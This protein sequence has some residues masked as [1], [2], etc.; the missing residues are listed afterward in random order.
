LFYS[1]VAPNHNFQVVHPDL[2]V[3]VL[4]A[5]QFDSVLDHRLHIGMMANLDDFF[6]TN[7]LLRSAE[8]N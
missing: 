2:S 1:D 5:V 6:S 4:R 3:P 8:I 7:S